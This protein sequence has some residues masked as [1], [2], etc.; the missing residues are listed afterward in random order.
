MMIVYHA[1][2]HKDEDSAWGVHFPDLPGCF[3]AADDLA[4]VQANASEA[5]ML[6]LEGEKAPEPSA[7]EKIR[8]MAADD[9][10]EGAFLLAVP[11]VYVSNR[12][13]R[14]NISIDRGV[15]DAIDAAATARKLTRSAFLTEAARNEIEGRH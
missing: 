15:L 11:Y 2:V 1:V 4:D 5:V 9:L 7:I 10:A 6:Y 14:I 12:P 3:S 8:D 13:Q